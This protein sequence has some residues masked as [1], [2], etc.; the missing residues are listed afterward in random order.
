[1]PKTILIVDDSATPTSD[2]AKPSITQI[3]QPK[4]G[5]PITYSPGK[6]RGQADDPGDLSR[7]PNLGESYRFWDAEKGKRCRSFGGQQCWCNNCR[8]CSMSAAATRC[9]SNAAG[10]SAASTCS[11]MNASN[12]LPDKL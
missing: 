1:M 11:V 8:C 9:S 2:P 5:H 10:C 4:N 6:E 12:R 7:L 3:E